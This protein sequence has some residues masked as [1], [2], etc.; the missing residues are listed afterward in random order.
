M[1]PLK[2]RG[3]GIDL[4]ELVD[5]IQSREISLP[6]L[7]RFSDILQSR[8]EKLQDCFRKA[9]RQ[10]DYQGDYY[11]VYPIKVNQQRQ[12]VEEIVTFGREYNVG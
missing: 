5:E 1:S 11:G 10:Y 9:I 7:I 8:I 2:N 6:V 4:K 3:I 12:V